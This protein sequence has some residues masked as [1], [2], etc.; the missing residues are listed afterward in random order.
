[1][2]QNW[3]P[4]SNIVTLTSTKNIATHLIPS[5]LEYIVID[6]AHDNSILFQIVRSF[7]SVDTFSLLL[8]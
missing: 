1:M 4:A 3:S 8:P 5:D 7:M 6:K 2:L